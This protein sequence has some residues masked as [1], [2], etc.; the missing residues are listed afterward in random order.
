VDEICDIDITA[1]DAE[2][3]AAFTRSLVEDRLAASGNLIAPVRS[4]YRWRDGIEEADEARVVLHTRRSLV[5]AIIERLEREHPYEI[6]GVRII[7]I[8]ASDSYYRWVL[9]ST[10]GSSSAGQ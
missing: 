7:P 1:P 4:V 6:P 9:D 8:T 5:P 10:D 3:L 2:W